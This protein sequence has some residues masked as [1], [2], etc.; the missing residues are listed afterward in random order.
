M[1][2]Y[3]VRLLHIRNTK[4]L[5]VC[6]FLFSYGLFLISYHIS[7]SLYFLPLNI[8]Y[9]LHVVNK[10]RPLMTPTLLVL[11]LVLFPFHW[12]WGETCDWLLTRKCGKDDWMSLLWLRCI[13]FHLASNLSK[14]SQTLFR[15]CPIWLDNVGNHVEKTQAT[16]K[17]EWLLGRRKC[18]WPLEAE[19][20]GP[21][22]NSKQ[23]VE[24]FSTNT[25]R[26]LFLPTSWVSL[27]VGFSP[28][29]PLFKNTTQWPPW[30][31]PCK[32]ENKGS[33]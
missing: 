16:R 23:E 27:E 25:S 3:T 26:K 22:T 13:K 28:A 1:Y 17:Y 11:I 8:K 31:Y 10:F 32:A 33:S 2:Y 15:D 12:M 9:S 5:S 4:I 19:G 20:G 29:E 6:L 7:H 30:L 21:P 14:D 24:A 18:E